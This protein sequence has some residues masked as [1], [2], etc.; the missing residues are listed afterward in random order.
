MSHGPVKT[1]F[2][3][4]EELKQYQSS[5]QQ[6]KNRKRRGPKNQMEW[7]WPEGIKNREIGMKQR[8]G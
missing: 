2:L 7:R 1:Y 5:K 4:P 8:R 3:S 6:T